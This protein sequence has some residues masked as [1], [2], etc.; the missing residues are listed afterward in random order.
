MAAVFLVT[1]YEYSPLF[2]IAVVFTCFIVTTGLVLGWFGWDVPVILRNSEETQF[3]TRAFKKQMRQVKNPFGLE[4]TNSSA[5][6]LATGMALRTDCLEDSRLTCYWGC[7]VQKLYEALQK[8]AYCFRISTPQALEEALYSDYLHR[9]QYFIKK[10]SKEEIYCQLPSDTEI[11]DFGP[12]PR[13]RYP[14]V[15]LL[16]LADED[17]REIYDIISMVSVIHIPDKTY[18]LPC[19]ILY[20]YLILA[21]GQFYD[22]KQLFMSA[23][24]SP[25]PSND[26]SPEDRSVEQSLLEKV[27]L[28]GNDG[29]PVEESSRDCVVCQ[30]G[31]VNW[32]L[33]PCRH[34]CLCDSCVRYFKQ[35]PMCRQFV[36]ESFA[37]CGQKEPDKDLLETS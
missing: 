23:N 7:S 37:L 28:A 4:I 1:L 15:A 33:L 26:E 24:N 6:S 8:H 17:D 18:K 29:D 11:E 22:L 20:Q 30:N 14:L 19:R 32:V 31:G 21:Q 10:H 13:S 35:C 2:Y 36:Q 5:A 34:A 9:E 27:G 3:S 12:V 25:P 16:T